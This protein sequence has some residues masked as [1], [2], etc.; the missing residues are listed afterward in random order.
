MLSPLLSASEAGLCHEVHAGFCA[1]GSRQRAAA[2][3]RRCA[4][5]QPPLSRRCRFEQPPAAVFAISA[6][7]LAIS[8][9]IEPIY[10]RFGIR[11]RF[12]AF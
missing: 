6:R 5:Q 4:E 8:T 1:G 3:E 9:R 10:Y 12:F 2:E 11:L 7:R